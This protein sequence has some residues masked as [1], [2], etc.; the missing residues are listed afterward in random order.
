MEPLRKHYQEALSCCSG[1]SEDDRSAARQFQ[2]GL[3]N[4]S[5]AKVIADALTDEEATERLRLHETDNAEGVN[6]GKRDVAEMFTNL[7][8]RTASQRAWS[9]VSWEVPPEQWCGLLADDTSEAQACFEQMR[10]DRD[11]VLKAIALE[12]SPD[13]QNHPG[14]KARALG[15]WTL[16]FAK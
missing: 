8:I 3:S 13:F 11:A 1:S 15:A 9:C 4:R 14:R 6:E 12:Q 2:A 7:V 10:S 16:P 5:W